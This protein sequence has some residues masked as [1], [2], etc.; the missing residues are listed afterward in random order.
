MRILCLILSVFATEFSFGQI[1]GVIKDSA[2]NEPIPYVNIW[3][4]NESIGTTSN[5]NGV[6][7]LST[8]GNGGNVIFSSIG[9]ETLK[10]NSQLFNGVVKLKPKITELQEVVVKA[11]E[12]NNETI[13][14]HFE[15]WW[16][17]LY[18][19]C[20]NTPWIAARFFDY[21]EDYNQT[22]FLK[23]IRVF[24]K[25]ELKES[26]FN[27]RL[28]SVGDDGKPFEYIYDKNILGVARKGKRITEVDISELNI[29]FP[30]KGVFV[31]VEWLI[32][33]SNKYEY[34]YTMN[35]FNVDTNKY[36]YTQAKKKS[37]E[38][39]KG[40]RYAPFFGTVI[41][42]T[43]KNS[44]VY[45]QGKWIKIWKNTGLSDYYKDKYNLPAIELTLTD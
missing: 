32:I 30:D 15:K 42:E 18:F 20:N 44:W 3:V 9:Y 33:D 1:T 5:E 28:Y 43:D 6:F 14:G 19:A 45:I 8:N 4:E 35:D 34:T 26:I 11:K 24:T 31:A 12:Q 25:S 2:S 29:K 37:K 38:K 10:I 16:I 36:E 23:K 41:S 27:I 7:T 17:R 39:L 21:N 40:I 13:I 22:P